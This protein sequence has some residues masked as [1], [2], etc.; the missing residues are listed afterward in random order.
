MRWEVESAIYQTSAGSKTEQVI[1]GA[2][3]LEVD[4]LFIPGASAVLS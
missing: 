1:A 2:R 3:M 4:K